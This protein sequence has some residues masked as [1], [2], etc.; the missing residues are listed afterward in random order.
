MRYKKN[1]NTLFIEGYLVILTI[2]L[3]INKVKEIS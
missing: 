1:I 3:K 2:M